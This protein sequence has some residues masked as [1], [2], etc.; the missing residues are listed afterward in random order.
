MGGTAIA[1]FLSWFVG[2]VVSIPEFGSEVLART[3]PN[4]VDL[5]IAVTAGVISGFAKIRKG[6]SDAL[7]GTAIGSCFNATSMCSRFIFLSR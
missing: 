3:Q 6:V 7:A 5:G 1:L 2:A 4:L